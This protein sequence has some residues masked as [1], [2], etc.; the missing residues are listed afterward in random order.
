MSH[1][2]AESTADRIRHIVDAAG[3]DESIAELAN[4]I[5]T[6]AVDEGVVSETAERDG[7]GRF[8]GGD[9]RAFPAS[10]YPAAVYAAARIRDVP[11]KPS[12]VADATPDAAIDS[13][14]VAEYYRQM[15]S[16]LPYTVEPEDPADWVRRL[17]D[18]LAVGAAFESEAVDL[19][20]DATADGLHVGKSVSGFAAAVVY[21]TSEYRD[22]G[23]KQRDIADAAD[24]AL[25]TI[26]KQYRDVLALRDDAIETG[27]ADS[28]TRVVNDVCDRV[29]GIDWDVRADAQDIAAALTDDG[30]DFVNRVDPRG[31]A[32]G[33]VWVA[34]DDRH[35]DASQERIGDV[36]GVSKSTV[37][38]R[39][40]DIREWRQR[41]QFDGMT[42]NK[43]KQLAADHDV[44]VGQ[45]PEREYLIDRL[46]DA[47]V[48]L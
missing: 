45:T 17:C 41:A 26:R 20:N 31:V 18:D 9:E 25:M 28:I 4:T 19:C 30:A 14:D 2:T 36:A 29:D 15:L 3:F 22:S 23:L 12:E 38:N 48:R 6:N 37:V 11:T 10:A 40:Q 24:V 32:A 44:D 7:D 5:L 27:D 35:V 43:L 42:Y 34:C 1:A 47:G 8:A 46:V 33:V 13:D 39:V 16:A 21:A